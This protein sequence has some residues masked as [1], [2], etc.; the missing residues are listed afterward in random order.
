MSGPVG[1]GDDLGLVRV[2]SD[3]GL[4][5]GGPR[6]SV[7]V[8]EDDLAFVGLA[9]RVVAAVLGVHVLYQLRWIQGL[10]QAV[11]CD[12]HFWVSIDEAEKVL[13]CIFVLGGDMV[14]SADEQRGGWCELCSLA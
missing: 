12:A 4:C 14:E 9:D 8:E 5:L 6:D 7:A 1:E 11:E 13:S 2:V 3:D 10:V